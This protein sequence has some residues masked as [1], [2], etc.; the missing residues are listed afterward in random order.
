MILGNKT[1]WR[2]ARN[3]QNHSKQTWLVFTSNKATVQEIVFLGGEINIHNKHLQLVKII[4]MQNNGDV[5]VGCKGPI[6]AVISAVKSQVISP[7]FPFQHDFSYS[8]DIPWSGIVD[9][10]LVTSIAVEKWQNVP[11]T[12]DTKSK[13]K[14]WIS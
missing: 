1:K 8:L 5:A 13:R 11:D 12:C 9:N 3:K 7:I 10:K 6:S 4:G 2:M 14:L